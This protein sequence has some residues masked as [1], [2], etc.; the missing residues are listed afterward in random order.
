[1]NLAILA[2]LSIGGAIGW[3]A[4]ALFTYGLFRSR[5]WGEI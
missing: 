3:A 1:M 2:L 4:L 5:W